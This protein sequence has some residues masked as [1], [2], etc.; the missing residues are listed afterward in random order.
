MSLISVYITYP[1]QPSAQAMVD[2]LLKEKLIA[3]GNIF[4][5]QS[6]Y[7]W[8]DT[9]ENE[10]EYVSLV[11]TSLKHWESLI[12]IVEKNHAYEVPCIVKYTIETNPAYEKWVMGKVR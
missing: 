4:P 9:I 12:D 2:L 3:C 10:N 6:L 1:D 5:I 11:K 7:E 8:K